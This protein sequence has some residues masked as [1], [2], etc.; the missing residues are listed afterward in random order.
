MTIGVRKR[1]WLITALLV[2]ALGVCA[3]ARIASIRQDLRGRAQEALAAAG[4]PFYG[5]DI[6]GRDVVLHGIVASEERASEITSIL[7]AVSGVRDVHDGLVVERIEIRTAAA[8]MR[9]P[10]LRIQRLGERVFLAGRLPDEES[11]DRLRAAAVRAFGGGNVT[12]ELRVDSTVGAPP[13]VSTGE[14]VVELLGA[15]HGNGRLS[16]EGDTALLFGLVRSNSERQQLIDDASSIAALRWQYDL[17]A[18]DGAIG[19]AGSAP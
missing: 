11:A 17:V 3:T 9:P 2:V 13:W 5:L 7:A 14:Q 16:I 12:S 4:V 8:V 1:F 10:S 18:I 6:S 15:V 19:D